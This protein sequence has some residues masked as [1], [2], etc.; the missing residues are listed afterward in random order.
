MT[1]APPTTKPLLCVDL[2]KRTTKPL[3]LQADYKAGPLHRLS[4]HNWNHETVVR[5]PV[6]NISPGDK[7][8]ASFL[9]NPG[10][11]VRSVF[12]D[13]D[14][15]GEILGSNREWEAGPNLGRSLHPASW[16]TRTIPDRPSCLL[17][18]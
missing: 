13:R 14:A 2:A 3:I 11:C 18:L 1:R 4:S 17:K 15:L 8:R 10:P 16:G 7:M 9:L 5:F 6:A 12:P